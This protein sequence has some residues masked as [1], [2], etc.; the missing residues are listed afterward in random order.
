[1]VHQE[2]LVEL[3]V[4]VLLEQAVVMAHPELTDM[5]V[6]MVR[7]VLRVFLVRM[8][9]LGVLVLL[10]QAVVMAHPELTDMMAHLE[11]RELLD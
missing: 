3:V 6:Q 7:M 8:A 9:R 11:H 2:L 4:V 1:M 5:M 10:E